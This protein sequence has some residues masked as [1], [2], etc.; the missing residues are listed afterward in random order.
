MVPQNDRIGFLPPSILPMTWACLHG[1]ILS[2][3]LGMSMAEEALKV[4][5]WKEE[6][7]MYA[8]RRVR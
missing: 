4:S 6:A 2:L 8:L 7:Y 5:L 3:V 1:F